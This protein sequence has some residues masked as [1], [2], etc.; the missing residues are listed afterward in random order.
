MII[1]IF[2]VV[3]CPDPAPVLNA[4]VTPASPYIYNTA[5]TYTCDLSYIHTSGDLTR[6]CQA[7]FNWSGTAPVCTGK[8]KDKLVID[9]KIK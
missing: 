4:T 2:T 1:L 7:D 5:I 9:F 3:V 8:T 6:T